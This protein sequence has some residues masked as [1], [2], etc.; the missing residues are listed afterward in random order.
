M[1]ERKIISQGFSQD[2]N[3]SITL[4]RSYRN[5][6][7]WYDVETDKWINGQVQSFVKDTLSLDQAFNFFD[8]YVKN[9]NLRVKDY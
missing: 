5:F 2:G 3:R 1:I 7:T 6:Q 8:R 9:H 4:F